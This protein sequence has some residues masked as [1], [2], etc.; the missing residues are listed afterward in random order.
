MFIC[1]HKEN[2]LRSQKYEHISVYIL[3]L[4]QLLNNS[5]F[6]GSIPG[7]FGPRSEVS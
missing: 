7:H 1:P 4:G 3:D 6:W 2:C 5:R